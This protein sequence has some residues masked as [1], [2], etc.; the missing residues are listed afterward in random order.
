MVITALDSPPGGW[1][2]RRPPSAGTTRARWRS[3]PTPWSAGPSG[4]TSNPSIVLEALR[5]AQAHWVPRVHGLAAANPDWSELD[6]TWAIVI[7]YRLHFPV[8]AVY[9]PR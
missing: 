4:A 9:H 5:K 3:S 7:D 8:R 6:L 1:C 2:G